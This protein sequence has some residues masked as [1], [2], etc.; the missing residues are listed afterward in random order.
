MTH[1]DGSEDWGLYNDLEDP[2]PYF[3]LEDDEAFLESLEKARLW[4]GL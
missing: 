4:L 3:T 2:E 1:K